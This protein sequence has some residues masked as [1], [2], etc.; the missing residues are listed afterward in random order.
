MPFKERLINQNNYLFPQ[1]EVEE[2]NVQ[3]TGAF[4]ITSEQDFAIE[5]GWLPLI[6]TYA[7]ENSISM[8][9]ATNHSALEFLNFMNYFTRK[10]QL[11]NQMIQRANKQN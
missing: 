11:D 6:H 9:E 2:N 4:T 7:K 10:V 8:K 1:T 3:H 5:F